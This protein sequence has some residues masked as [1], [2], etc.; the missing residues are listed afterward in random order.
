MLKKMFYF[1]VALLVCF[2]AEAQ[3]VHTYYCHK[4]LDTSIGKT[5]K[6][7]KLEIKYL[8]FANDCCYECD[9]R[10]NRL[11]P[12]MF[13]L[14]V[15]RKKYSD[16]NGVTVYVNGTGFAFAISA[17]KSRLNEYHS[18]LTHLITVYDKQRPQFDDIIMY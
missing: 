7:K 14:D 2:V 6:A 11:R 17:D 4:M 18:R 10:G 15:F 16:A 8:V 1:T 5:T 9:A 3:T 12:D 13:N